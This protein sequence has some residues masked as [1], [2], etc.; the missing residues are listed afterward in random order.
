MGCE[1]LANPR[2]SFACKKQWQTTATSTSR[3]SFLTGA[4]HFEREHVK[5]LADFL[6]WKRRKSDILVAKDNGH[7]VMLIVHSE[8]SNVV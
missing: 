5:A 1:V 4:N 8:T 2:R 3:A 7:F 6:R